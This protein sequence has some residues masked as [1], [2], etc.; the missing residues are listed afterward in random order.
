MCVCV[1]LDVPELGHDHVGGGGVQGGQLL[2]Q[3]RET[4]QRAQQDLSLH[5]RSLRERDDGG[6]LGKERENV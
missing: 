1:Y 2:V 6:R 4:H 3:V 5:T